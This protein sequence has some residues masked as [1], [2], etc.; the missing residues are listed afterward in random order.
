MYTF[1]HMYYGG[2]GIILLIVS[3]IV[4]HVHT[5]EFTIEKRDSETFG[6]LVQWTPMS[7]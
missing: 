1:T 3:T 6:I 2:G 7:D 4:I 5:G